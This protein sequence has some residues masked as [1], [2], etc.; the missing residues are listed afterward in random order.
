MKIYIVN[1]K[2]E[3]I[4]EIK[5]GFMEIEIHDGIYE[6]TAIATTR[7]KKGS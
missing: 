7:I 6:I 3:R 5:N 1:S 4:G 2:S